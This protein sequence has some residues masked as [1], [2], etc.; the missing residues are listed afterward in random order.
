[1]IHL[2]ISTPGTCIGKKSER[3]VVRTKRSEEKTDIKEIPL[4]R[5]GHITIES[6]GVG[7][8]TDVLEACTIRGISISFITKSGDPWGI[9]TSPFLTKTVKTRRAQFEAYRDRR[10]VTLAKEWA[11]TKIYN[12]R[13][14][15]LYYSKYLK[16]DSKPIIKDIN[17]A[18]E[19]LSVYERSLSAIDGSCIDDIRDQLMGIEGATSAVYWDAVSC[20][21]GKEVFQGRETRG[22]R[23]PF[24]SCLNYGYGILYSSVASCLLR[25]GLDPFAGFVHADRPGKPSLVFDFIEEFRQPIVDR[26]VISLFNKKTDAVTL[27]NG[28]LD[29]SSRKTVAAR[30]L[31]KFD[32]E[33]LWHGHKIS[34]AAVMQRQARLIASFLRGESVYRGYRFKW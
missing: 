14:L 2:V 12:Q 30:V 32:S 9:L 26:A 11:S 25:S 16:K 18:V 28:L 21:T 24:N 13:S 17:S 19:K 29:E 6:R 23:D 3:L 1:M 5:I 4:F 8:S 7:I 15:L 31:S 20:I 34:M 33:V 22:A 10:S 27:I